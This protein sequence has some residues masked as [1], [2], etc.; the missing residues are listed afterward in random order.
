MHNR[1][2]PFFTVIL[3]AIASAAFSQSLSTNSPYSRYGLGEIRTRGYANTKALGG[4]SQ[5]IRNGT[6]VNYLNP[7]SYTAQDSMSFIFD[8]GLDGGMVN[9]SSQEQNNLNPFANLNHL[10]IQLPV[11]KWM[12]VSAGIQPYSNVGYNIKHI[13]MDPYLLSTIGPIKYYHKG[14]GGITQFYIG[15]AIE[16]LKNLSIGANMSYFMGALEHRRIIDFPANKPYDGTEELNSFVVRDVAF[17]FGAQYSLYFGEEKEY[18]LVVGAT[19]D[20]ETSLKAK[21]IRY[22]SSLGSSG[23]TILYNEDTQGANMLVPSN[24][25]GGF[26][27]SYKN[28]FM[29]GADYSFQDWTKAKF[30]DGN[31]LLAASNSLRVGVEYTPNRYDLKSYAKRMSYR[32]GYYNSN[33]SLKIANHHIKDYGITFGLGLPIRR[34]NSTF[35]IALELGTKGTKQDGLVRENYGIINFGFTFYD[36]WFIKQRIN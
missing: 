9:Y 8:F 10:A 5:G 25:S 30:F 12:G 18:R 2:A 34:S 19:L 16:P 24:Y 33:T 35:N 22:I 26:T 28:K 17:S 11:G 36:F 3:L 31:S 15:L 7:A 32:A 29:V 1:K 27:F 21:H 13:E 6:W 20:N 14:T 4:L 23:D